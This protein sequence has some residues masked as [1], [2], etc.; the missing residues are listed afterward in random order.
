[1]E[2]AKTIKKALSLILCAVMAFGAAPFAQLDLFTPQASA[3]DYDEP[4]VYTDGYYTFELY[5]FNACIIDVDESISGDVVIPS[6]LRGLLVSY[7]V[8][9][10][11]SYAFS[12][13]TNITSITIPNSV[14]T[15]GYCAFMSCTSLTSITVDSNNSYYSNDEFGVLF[16]KDKTELIQYPIGNT[17][18]SYTIPDSVTS[19]GENAFSDCTSL[20][21]VTIPDGVTRIGIWAFSYC[22]SLASITIPDS[23]T[24]IGV[25]AFIWCTSLASI[26]IP[27]SVTSIGEEAFHGCTSLASITIPDSVTYIGDGAFSGCISLKSITVDSN[28]KNYSN[29]EYG[30]LFN[31]DK[32]ELIQYPVGNTRTS[33]TISNSVTSI[34]GGA[35]ADCASLT[36]ITI[37]DSVTSIGFA[38]F[39]G[40]ISLASITIPDSVTSIGFAAFSGCISLASITI[41]DS[42]TS[43][44]NDAFYNTA[45][46]NNESNWENGVLYIGKHLIIAKETVSGSYAIKDGTKTIADYAFSWCESLTSIT[47]PDSVTS[48]GNLAFESCTSLASVT[49]GENSRLTSIGEYAFA[50]CESLA[51][52]TIPNSVTSIDYD[53]FEGC[54][55][56]ES[57]TIPN[58]VTSISSFAFA[59]CENL[60]SITIPDS[61]TSIGESAFRDCTSLKDVYYSGTESEWNAISIYDDNECLTE[62]NIHFNSTG[63]VKYPSQITIDYGDSIVLHVDESKIPDGGYV[64]WSSD[65]ENFTV[66]ASEDG[67][68]VTVTPNENGETNFT[69]TIFD[70]DGNV[71]GSDTQTMTSKVNLFIKIIA[72]FK[73][74]FGLNKVIPESLVELF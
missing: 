54:T 38:A 61:V 70:K 41:P 28:N 46:F 58:S 74:L 60:E 13:C 65:N 59:W 52:I 20:E 45:Y 33:Y 57:I 49:F 10:I 63:V 14:T 47:I 71:V 36:S 35:L 69:A 16:N 55:S 29:D 44:G 32:T 18:T 7:P 37:P 27:D 31:K 53:A 3:A 8:K 68:T 56:L 34:G 23:V 17:R 72:F 39:S 25:W 24:S 22:T 21:S 4:T 51:S 40:C 30:V 66:T 62:A 73:K 12:D 19:I 1:M 9:W 6:T 42:V 2:K 15:I 50:Y 48:I 67:K 43:I 64:E 11:Y 5:D 26:S